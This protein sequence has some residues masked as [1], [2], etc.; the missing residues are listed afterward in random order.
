MA[1]DLLEEEAKKLLKA[2]LGDLGDFDLKEPPRP[3]LGDL[4]SS[5]CFRISKKMKR[6]PKELAEEIAKKIKES[7]TS[8]SL[9]ADINA[10]DGFLNFKMNFEK[11]A[12]T[13]ILRVLKEDEKYGALDLGHNKKVLIEHT[14]VNPNKAMHIGHARNTCLGDSL[15]RLLHFTGHRVYALNYIDDTG[16]QIADVVVGFKYLGFSLE[17]PAGMRFD[18]YCGDEVYVKV[19]KSYE[20][21]PEL[22]KYR[23]EVLRMIEEGNNE[24]ARFTKNIAERVL[25]DQLKTCWRLGAYFDLLNWESDIVKTGLWEEVFNTLKSKGLI[26]YETEGEYKGCWVVRLR[27]IPRFAKETDKIVVRSDGTL[28]YIAK[29]LPYAMWKVGLLN[30][31]FSY[32]IYLEKQPNGKALWSTSLKDSEVQHPDFKG[33]DLAI[34][35]I[36]VRQS[37]LQEVINIVLN[38]LGGPELA[39][40]YLHYSYEVVALSRETAVAMGARDVDSKIVHMSGRH[41]IYFNVDDVLDR[42]KERAKEESRKRNPN[43]SESWLNEVAEDIAI[44]ALRYQLIKADR[45]RLIVFDI[46]EALKLEGDTGPYLQYT[47]A[48]ARSILR[49]ANTYD[50]KLFDPKLLITE[51]EKTLIKMIGKF[52]II[53]RDAVMSLEPQRLA[54]YAYELSNSFNKFYEKCP[55]LKE[56]EPLRSTRLAIVD[57]F[58]R[59]ARNVFHLLGVKPLESM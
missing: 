15:V 43:A 23:A 42:L 55:V 36:D 29:D 19:N 39:R 57:S 2:Q 16:S 10:I 59:A 32:K 8:E 6:N 9:I 35:V 7:L 26:V 37:R 48:R 53:I 18:K 1:F 14:N 28:T 3:E 30:K 21:K 11:F 25:A 5:I 58:T 47:Y 44:S 54:V 46:N 27:H 33:S 40:K 50:T 20:E 41:G 52:P 24:I 38:A 17:P 31:D 22:E 4:A 45:N 49:K 13:T 12:S 34:S 56:N 51:E